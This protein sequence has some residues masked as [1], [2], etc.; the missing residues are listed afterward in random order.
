MLDQSFHLGHRAASS[1]RNHRELFLN[2]KRGAGLLL[3]KVICCWFPRSA[4][5]SVVW[6]RVSQSV[7]LA[8]ESEVTA[9]KHKVMLWVLFLLLNESKFHQVFG[10]EHLAGKVFLHFFGPWC[11]IVIATPR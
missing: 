9:L 4:L 3:G 11:V 2:P 5:N 1:T 6:D 7:A 10:N 8:L